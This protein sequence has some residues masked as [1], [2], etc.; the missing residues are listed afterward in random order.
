MDLT[1]DKYYK[2]KQSLLTK[3]KNRNNY[4]YHI[5]RLSAY[6]FYHNKQYDEVANIYYHIIE[7]KQD[8]LADSK[9]FME[10]LL[11]LIR[12]KHNIDNYTKHIKYAYE[13]IYKS[14]Y[15]DQYDLHL[16]DKVFQFVNNN[17]KL[18]NS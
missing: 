16:A 18:A 5:M 15:S 17:N 13:T 4:K 3:M 8:T 14:D 12:Q 10:S 7:N 1:N 11:S 6:T 2:I 9:N